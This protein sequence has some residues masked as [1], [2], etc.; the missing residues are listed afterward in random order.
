MTSQPTSGSTGRMT[1]ESS[2]LQDKCL[3]WLAMLLMWR[4]LILLTSNTKIKKAWG[5]SWNIWKRLGWRPNLLSILRRF[6]RSTTHSARLRKR[7]S[8]TKR[9]YWNFKKRK[10]RARLLLISG[11]RWSTL[12]LSGE[13]KIHYK[14]MNNWSISRIDSIWWGL[15]FRV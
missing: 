6:P 10:R 1:T 13:R 11:K 9:W 3:H 12:R 2:I 5:K 8:I 4:V 14:D 15:G 7:F